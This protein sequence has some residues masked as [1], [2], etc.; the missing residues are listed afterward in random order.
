MSTLI[1]NVQDFYYRRHYGP[2]GDEKA[3]AHISLCVIFFVASLVLWFGV[4][5]PVSRGIALGIIGFPLVLAWFGFWLV[6]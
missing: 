2:S 4:R 1:Y 6:G 3:T 5:T